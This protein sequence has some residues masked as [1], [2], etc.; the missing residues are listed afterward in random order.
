M[1]KFQTAIVEQSAQEMQQR[2]LAAVGN[3]AFDKKA[4]S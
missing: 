3:T 2:I 4:A 1:P